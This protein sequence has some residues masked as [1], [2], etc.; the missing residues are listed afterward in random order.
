MSTTAPSQINDQPPRHV[1]I[2]MDGN[3]RWANQR[4]LPRVEGHRAGAKSVRMVV[5]E[6]RRL[7]IRYL[8]LFAFSTENWQRPAEEVGALMGL[9]AQYLEHEL[10]LM[11]KN[12]VRLRAIG[13]LARLPEAVRR[14]LCAT[15][16][17]TER[18]NGLDLILAISYGGREELT[19]ACKSIASDVVQGKL[20]PDQITNQC[21]RD[22]LYAPDV[23][24]PD[25]LIRTSDEYRISNFL[26]WQLAYSEIV[27]TPVLW[28]DFNKQEYMACLEAYNKR[29]RRFGLTSE[30][31]EEARARACP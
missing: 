5:E 28:P 11:L 27:V 22:H 8:T 20:N 17:K 30:Q 16:Q 7:G 2:V 12:D 3:G 31:I 18:A 13:D 4:H 10:T 21:I 23:P 6:S 19:S 29:N 9:F 1:A 25:L 26:L 14:S 24:D 15:M